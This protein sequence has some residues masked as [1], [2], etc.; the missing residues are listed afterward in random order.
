M[1]FQLE[2]FVYFPVKFCKK[3]PK[4]YIPDIELEERYTIS[5]QFTIAQEGQTLARQFSHPYKK[6]GEDDQE[7]AKSLYWRNAAFAAHFQPGSARR[8]D[9]ALDQYSSP[10]SMAVGRVRPSVKHC[11]AAFVS[12]ALDLRGFAQIKPEG[13]DGSVNTGGAAAALKTIPTFFDGGAADELLPC[14]PFPSPSLLPSF[15]RLQSSR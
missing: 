12:S 4:N 7:Y 8:K 11:G 6:V 13:S 9:R 15:R 3:P 2:F 1:L 5:A 14:P 10:K